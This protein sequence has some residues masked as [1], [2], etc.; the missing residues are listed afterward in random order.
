M[1]IRITTAAPAAAAALYIAK[2]MRAG[3]TF[4]YGARR[5]IGGAGDMRVA[6]KST[7][8]TEAAMPSLVQPHSGNDRNAG[9]KVPQFPWPESHHISQNKVS[10]N[11][12]DLPL[13]NNAEVQNGA[14]KTSQQENQSNT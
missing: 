9:G 13:K 2:L 8:A 14:A 6:N 12:Q 10:K 7:G 1:R 5:T 3:R 11:P 4:F